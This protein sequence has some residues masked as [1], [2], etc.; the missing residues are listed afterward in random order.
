MQCG[1]SCI[2]FFFF[3]FFVSFLSCRMQTQKATEVANMLLRSA[4]SVLPKQKKV[5]SV[6]EYRHA[7]VA[8][9]RRG[10]VQQDEEGKSLLEMFS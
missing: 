9:K 5:L 1:C 3:F 10:K 8:C 2:T 7:M 6:T 4:E